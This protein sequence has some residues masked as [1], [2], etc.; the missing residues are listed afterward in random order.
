MRTNRFLMVLLAMLALAGCASR[1]I[2]ERITQADPN[3][4]YRPYLLMPKRVNNDPGT[5]SSLRSPVAA[6]APRR[7]PTACWKSSDAP[8][9]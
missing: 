5:F 3:T 1:P 4:G 7:C 6:P 8:R 2:N 9:S